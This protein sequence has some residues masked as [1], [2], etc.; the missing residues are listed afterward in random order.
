VNLAD[1]NVLASRFGQTVA[2]E[3]AASAGPGR[4]PRDFDV[5]LDTLRELLE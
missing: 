1:F 3:G 2:P 5:D 4:A